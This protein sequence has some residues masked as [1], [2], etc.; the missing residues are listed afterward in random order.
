MGGWMAV[1][2]SDD[3]GLLIAAST[4]STGYFRNE[5]GLLYRKWPGQESASAQHIEPTEWN[6]RMQLINE[7]ADAI[8]ELWSARTTLSRG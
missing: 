4:I 5:V 6:T 2:G 1:P 8:A 7:R 3:T